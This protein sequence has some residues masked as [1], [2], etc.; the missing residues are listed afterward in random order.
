MLKA[1]N[2]SFIFKLEFSLILFLIICSCNVESYYSKPEPEINNSKTINNSTNSEL[3]EKFSALDEENCEIEVKENCKRFYHTLKLKI[4]I[5]DCANFITDSCT[6][7]GTM[8]VTICKYDY[9]LIVDFVEDVIGHDQ[10][11][12]LDK[13]LHVDD[14]DCIHNKTYQ[15]FITKMMP[16]IMEDYSGY[17]LCGDDAFSFISKYTKD[18]CVFPCTFYKEGLAYS[19]LMQCGETTSCCVRL[20]EW[21]T[22]DDGNVNSETFD[23]YQIGNCSSGIIPCKPT[24]FDP[25][26]TI[27]QCSPR[28]CNDAPFPF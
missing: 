7:Y 16:I 6:V 10:S 27:N 22:D 9:G 25:F 23:S 2:N 21:C 19:K 12:I 15:A 20:D 28:S 17:T 14:W 3:I 24:K 26:P 18:V 8:Q 1:N 4:K 13:D 11:C 5:S